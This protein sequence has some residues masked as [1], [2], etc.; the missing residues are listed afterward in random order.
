MF[1]LE[2]NIAFRKVCIDISGSHM[3]VTDD[4]DSEYG[5]ITGYEI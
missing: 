4:S 3:T 5:M 2:T 1:K